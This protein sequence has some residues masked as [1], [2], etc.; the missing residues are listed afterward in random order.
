MGWVPGT[1]KESIKQ[2]LR[3]ALAESKRER[4]A[5]SVHPSECRCGGH[6]NVPAS[7]FSCGW[8]PCEE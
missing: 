8:V 4:L 7:Q 1:D 2:R 5:K 6:G 3:F